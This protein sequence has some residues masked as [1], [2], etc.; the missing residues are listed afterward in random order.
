M[1]LEESAQGY[2]A[3]KKPRPPLEDHHRALGT[4]LRQGPKRRLFLMSEVPLKQLVTTPLGASGRGRIAH[5]DGLV[6]VRRGELGIQRR[7]VST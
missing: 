6:R 5:C 3:H 1:V 4:V 7:T 2:P